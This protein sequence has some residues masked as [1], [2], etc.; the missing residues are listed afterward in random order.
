V[1]AIVYYGPAAHPQTDAGGKVLD[2]IA[3]SREHNDANVLSLGARFL[4]EDEAKDA[5]KRWLETPFSG[6]ERHARRVRMIDEA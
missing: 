4:T 2:I 6:E 5:V 1:R 3:S